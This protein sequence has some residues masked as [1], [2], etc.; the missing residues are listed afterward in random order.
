MEKKPLV[1][2]KKTCKDCKK[3]FHFQFTPE[4]IE[5]Y[6]NREPVQVCFP[7]LSADERELFTSLGICGA[8]FDKLFEGMDDD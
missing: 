1:S 3:E 8:C 7:E 2:V 5:D 6:Y 4:Q